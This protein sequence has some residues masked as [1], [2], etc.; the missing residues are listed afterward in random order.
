MSFSYPSEH[1]KT[2]VKT[3]MKNIGLLKNKCRLYRGI[4]W[5]ESNVFHLQFRI[6]FGTLWYRKIRC[7]PIH[8]ITSKRQD[9]TTSKATTT[10]KAERRTNGTLLFVHEERKR[11]RTATPRRKR[12]Q[13]EEQMGLC[14]LLVLIRT[15]FGTSQVVI[16]RRPSI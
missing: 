8:K 1:L 10:A 15:S 3:R 2:Y 14:L 16:L 13:Q 6:C 5:W 12:K 11:P 4:A 7:C 9:R